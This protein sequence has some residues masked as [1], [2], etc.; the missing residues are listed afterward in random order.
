[1]LLQ[2]LR[3]KTIINNPAFSVKDFLIFCAELNNPLPI[4]ELAQKVQLMS[5]LHR[6]SQRDYVNLHQECVCDQ[7]L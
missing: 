5:N 4:F 1:M 3:C 6:S 2:I 7:Y